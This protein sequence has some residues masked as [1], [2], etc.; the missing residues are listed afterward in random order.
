MMESHNS[1]HRSVVYKCPV[2]HSGSYL[3]VKGD[4]GRNPHSPPI[5]MIHDI[6]EKYRAFEP[7]VEHLLASGHRIYRFNIFGRHGAVSRKINSDRV[8]RLAKELLQVLCWVRHQEGGVS[9]ILVSQG[10]GT[11][12]ALIMGRTESRFCQGMIFASPL[13]SQHFS[14]PVYQMALLKKL[15]DTFPEISLPKYFTPP[16]WQ[17]PEDLE[18]EIH[19]LSAGLFCDIWQ[20]LSQGKKL[21][22]RLTLPSLILS[23][24]D[25]PSYNHEALKRMVAK[26][27]HSEK[28]NLHHFHTSHHKI[29]SSPS[30]KTQ[31][32]FKT[33]S[34]WLDGFQKKSHEQ[35]SNLS[36]LKTTVS[37]L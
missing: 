12:L 32:I 23:P 19:P 36:C 30:H 2:D 13:F 11:L 29:L 20:H 3:F 26:H 25:L 9:P 15:S 6:G 22:H 27:P 37:N 18:E 5:L 34:H 10:F 16:I 21:F 8:Y 33:I 31:E 14:I 24:T 7:L 28:M 17:R 35:I 1:Y 4:I